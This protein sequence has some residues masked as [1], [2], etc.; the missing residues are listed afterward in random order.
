MSIST[1]TV[2]P[3]SVM[4]DSC[5]SGQGFA[6]IRGYCGRHR[7]P[8]VLLENVSSLFFKRKVEGKDTSA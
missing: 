5:Q 3:G 6:A 7:P 8:L 2:T 4:D 1:L